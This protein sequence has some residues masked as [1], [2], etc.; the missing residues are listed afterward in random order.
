MLRGLALAGQ[1]RATDSDECAGLLAEL[2]QVT[3]WLAARAAD[4]PDNFLHL[5]RLFEAERAWADGDFRAAV[6]AYD[7]ARQEAAQRQRPRHRALIAERAARFFS[8]TAPRTS[9]MTCSPRP[10]NSTPHGA[11]PRRSASWTGPT[12]SSG[13]QSAR[14]PGSARPAR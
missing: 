12:R 4:A 7:A 6:L 10:A 14:P 13:Y 5:L 3:Q 2:D 8:P 1:A 9:A 11:P